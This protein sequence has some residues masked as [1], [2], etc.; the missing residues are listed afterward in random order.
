ML[1][2][3][4]PGRRWDPE[5]KQWTVPIKHVDLVART[6]KPHGFCLAPEVTELVEGTDE[7]SP[8]L[9]FDGDDEPAVAPALSVSALNER[10]R[11]ALRAELPDPLWVIGEVLDFDKNAG[12][13]HIFFTLV[14][15]TEGNERHT[16]RVDVA[17]FGGTWELLS[18]QLQQRGLELKDGTQ[19]R[20]LVRV[21]LYPASGRYQLVME[22]IDPSFTL[23]AMAMTR[24]KILAELRGLNLERANAAIPI[25]QPVLRVACLSSVDSDGW[26]DF[27]RQLEAAALGFSVTCYHVR[28]QGP[29]LRPTVLAGLRWFAER[30]D[31]FDVLC[32][33]RG[34]GSRSDLAW[35]DDRD[36]ALSVARHPL[37]VVCG[38]G[39]Q[40]DQSVLD[41]ISRSHKTPTAV[42]AWLV[43]S[44]RDVQRQLEEQ[45]S[46]LRDAA[47]EALNEERE[48]VLRAANTLTRTLQARVG[49][50]RQALDQARRRL[51][52]AALASVAR[53]EER[54]LRHTSELHRQTKLVLERATSR[55]DSWAARQR[56]LDPAR[57]LERG[58]TL[59]RNA[60]GRV[61]GQAH[62]LT[63]GM[64]L[65]ISFH[66]G[67]AQVQT[68]RVFEDDK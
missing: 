34:G 23:G 1:G 54:R 46:R 55:L 2:G 47:M 44:V 21:D 30:R 28:V 51:R 13:K 5:S 4:L 49:G 64:A 37:P 66:D 24:E 6:F 62:G 65:D 35:F 59:V 33:I 61:V 19:I 27:Q 56:L 31:D 20:A 17:L 63:P 58:Y 3:T 39:H 9:P 18:R 15:K 60:D 50:E 16:A 12:R 32:I 25:T 14:E 42:G 8:S 40:R 7:G 52:R 43:D 29:E 11:A 22:D 68:T 53:Q 36:V 38:I 57:V 41:V 10:V 67:H 26:A 48:G 45:V